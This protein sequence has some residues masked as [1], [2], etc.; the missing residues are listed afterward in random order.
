MKGKLRAH[1]KKERKKGRKRTMIY[2]VPP[3][4]WP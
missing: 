2:F 3:R 1:E 4:Q